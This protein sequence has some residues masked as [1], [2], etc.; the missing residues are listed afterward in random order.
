MNLDRF[1]HRVQSSTKTAASMAREAFQGLDAMAAQDEYIHS[2]IINININGGSSSGNTIRG[3]GTAANR[4]SSRRPSHPNPARVRFSDRCDDEEEERRDPASSHHRPNGRGVGHAAAASSSSSSSS[5]SSC[6]KRGMPG[7]S[8]DPISARNPPNLI[9]TAKVTDDLDDKDVEEKRRASFYT[10]RGAN[11]GTV[12]DDTRLSKKNSKRFLDD[13]DERMSRPMRPMQIEQCS[14]VPGV[15]SSSSS[16]SSTGIQRWASWLPAGAAW[17]SN[18][19]SN[20]ASSSSSSSPAPPVPLLARSRRVP[21]SNADPEHDVDDDD[22]Y[23]VKSSAAMLGDDELAKLK[24]MME[25]TTARSESADATTAAPRPAAST[26]AIR[27]WQRREMFVAVT[28][29]LFLLVYYL[30]RDVALIDDGT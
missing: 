5:S 7:S 10:D 6:T 24:A 20:A 26:A 4:D 9:R 14:S 12:E 17:K 3:G 30:T 18:Q 15:S 13:L 1:V 8:S 27:V 2:G 19:S 22:E 11:E 23:R 16:S 29:I 21:S 25:G 28:L